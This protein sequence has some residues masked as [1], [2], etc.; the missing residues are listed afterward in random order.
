MEDIPFK[1]TYFMTRWGKSA[2]DIATALSKR[3]PDTSANHGEE[4]A[5]IPSAE[6]EN[7]TGSVDGPGS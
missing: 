6:D 2:E 4:Q 5:M 7:V 3:T 1:V